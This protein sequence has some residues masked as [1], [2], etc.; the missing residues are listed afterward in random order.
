ME[1]EREPVGTEPLL[2]ERFVE[3]PDRA[4][5]EQY[6]ASGR[7]LWNAGIFVWRTDVFLEAAARHLPGVHQ[8]LE[9]LAPALGSPGFE[10][11]ARRAFESIEA[12]SVD[13]GIMEKAE[14][15]WCVPAGFR[16]SDIGGW[17]A[18]AEAI[19]PDANGNRVRGPVVL[20][21]AADNVVI[22]D[23]GRPVVVLGVR[24]CIIVHG[25]GGTLVCDRD[26]A[27]RIKPLVEKVSE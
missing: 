23:K 27:G 24:H 1:L 8:A 15:V 17:P 12:I 2:V 9:P 3:K 14:D 5:A 4:T 19:P 7:Y 22:T 13:Y 20:E 21:D 10:E 26:A 25:P 18:E 6:V 16:W 11:A